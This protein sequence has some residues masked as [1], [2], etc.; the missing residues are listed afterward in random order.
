VQTDLAAFVYL[1]EKLRAAVEAVDAWHGRVHPLAVIVA[2]N[3]LDALA[4][5]PHL[6]AKVA[7]S[8]WPAPRC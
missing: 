4:R 2:E 8:T 5:Y 6:R 3:D 7:P 1:S